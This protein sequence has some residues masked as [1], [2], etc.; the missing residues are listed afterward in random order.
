MAQGLGHFL[1]T[2]PGLILWCLEVRALETSD[3]HCVELGISQLPRMQ[4]APHTQPH[5]DLLAPV[6]KI[7]N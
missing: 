5:V 1:E 4:I 2:D 3:P 7:A 6:V